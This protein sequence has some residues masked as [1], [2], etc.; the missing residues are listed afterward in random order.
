MTSLPLLPYPLPRPFFLTP[1]HIHNLSF[2][3]RVTN[4]RRRSSSPAATLLRKQPSP[5]ASPASSPPHAQPRRTPLRRSAAVHLRRRPHPAVN[6]GGLGTKME[7]PSMPRRLIRKRMLQVEGTIEP[8][9]CEATSPVADEKG[10]A[11]SLK[12]FRSKKK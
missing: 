4:R 3:S 11:K 12:V 10:R 9:Q 5:C 7:T 6:P 8:F 2:C 1:E